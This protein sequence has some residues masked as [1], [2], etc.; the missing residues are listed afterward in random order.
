MSWLVLLHNR[1]EPSEPTNCYKENILV[2][3]LS[4]LSAFVHSSSSS[5]SHSAM[6]SGPSCSTAHIKP[7]VDFSTNRAVSLCWVLAHR[8]P[9]SYL[10][11]NQWIHLGTVSLDFF[12][13][14][15]ILANKIWLGTR[16]I[17]IANVLSQ[18][19]SNC[20]IVFTHIHIPWTSFYMRYWS[21]L[22]CKRQQWTL[23]KWI[24]CI[25]SHFFK[26]LNLLQLLS[27]FN[28]L[29]SQ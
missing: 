16:V 26:P 2:S 9:S 7:Y 5:T 8:T 11:T 12:L 25:N 3:H 4:K 22:I 24:C 19:V 15:D 17:R 18:S 6:R 29:P 28:I 14:L 20:Y 21:V 27:L 10:H 23:L 13:E 1:T